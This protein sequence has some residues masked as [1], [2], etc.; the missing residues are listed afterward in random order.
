MGKTAQEIEALVTE[1]RQKFQAI[2]KHLDLPK[3]YHLNEE[4]P[5]QYPDKPKPEP[6]TK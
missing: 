4:L 2:E 5:P 1:F 3:D 6:K